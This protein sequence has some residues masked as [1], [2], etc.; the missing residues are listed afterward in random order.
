MHNERRHFGTKSQETFS[1]LETERAVVNCQINTAVF[2]EVTINGEIVS[3][4]PGA[5]L[6]ER[7]DFLG[8]EV[9]YGD[10]T[11]M[12]V[13]I[14][15]TRKL[16]QT[17][18]T[19]VLCKVVLINRILGRSNIYVGYTA[20]RIGH[21]MNVAVSNVRP[22]HAHIASSLPDLISTVIVTVYLNKVHIKR[23]NIQQTE[24]VLSCIPGHQSFGVISAE[25]TF[26][27]FDG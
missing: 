22:T 6:D 21:R 15:G 26:I 2:L 11:R 1:V 25:R 18:L 20:I 12:I 13:G 9:Y 23:V 7:T 4:E 10:F 5:G 3:C 24:V 16:I 19:Q 8:G 14:V 17:V 27:G